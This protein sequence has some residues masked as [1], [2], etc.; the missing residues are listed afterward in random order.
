MG[1]VGA[2]AERTHATPKERVHDWPCRHVRYAMGVVHHGPI[3]RAR[4]EGSMVVHPVRRKR[5]ADAH[6]QVRR[7]GLDSAERTNSTDNYRG[8]RSCICGRAGRGAGLGAG[9]GAR[10]AKLLFRKG[11]FKCRGSSGGGTTAVTAA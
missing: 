4:D 9:L 8:G 10:A 1:R 3:R 7:M 2:E 5:S 11:G 6:V